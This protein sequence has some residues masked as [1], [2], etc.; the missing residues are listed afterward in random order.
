MPIGTVFTIYGVLVLLIA[1]HRRAKATKLFLR[2]HP[3]VNS[4]GDDQDTQ[5]FETSGTTVIL[6][7]IVSVASYITLLVLLYLI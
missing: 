2:R 7:T 4:N 3:D 6:L 1:W 5:F